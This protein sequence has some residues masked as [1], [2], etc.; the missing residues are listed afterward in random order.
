[1]AMNDIRIERS[2]RS[3]IQTLNVI[4]IKDIKV[5]LD[6][7]LMNPSVINSTYIPHDRTFNINM[8]VSVDQFMRKKKENELHNMIHN[9][10]HESSDRMTIRKVIFND[11]ATIVF[12]E[13][14]TK[15][16]VKCHNEQYDPEKGL[17]MAIAKKACG[18]RGSYYGVFKKYLNEYE[19][20]K[21]PEFDFGKQMTFSDV[22]NNLKEA[23]FSTFA[24]NK[25]EEVFLE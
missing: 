24:N 22:L 4:G 23:M 20:Q 5:T 21:L 3:D 12:W 25:N 16:V 2:T 11:P 15:T 17:A 14:G 7:V 13:D 19:A 10:T 9:K 18:N 8:R 6:G 1:M